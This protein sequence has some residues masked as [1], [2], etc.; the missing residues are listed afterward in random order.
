LFA[1]NLSTHICFSSISFNI[2]SLPDHLDQMLLI[3]ATTDPGAHF[4]DWTDWFFGLH[5]LNRL[6]VAYV[7][8]R[9]LR[10]Q[11]RTSAEPKAR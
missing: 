8:G 9:K 1:S 2:T 6:P 4:A 11:T 10:M 5:K 7:P 3:K